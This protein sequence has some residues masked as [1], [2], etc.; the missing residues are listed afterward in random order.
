M[1]CNCGKNKAAIKGTVPT[2]PLILGTDDPALP[3]Q[4]VV[5][6]VAT[7]GVPVGATR[8]VRGSDVEQMIADEQLRLIGG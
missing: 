8:Y 2:N 5:M 6:L 7:G 1:G 3:V 4:R